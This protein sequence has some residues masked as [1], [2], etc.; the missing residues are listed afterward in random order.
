MLLGST[1]TLMLT[2]FDAAAVLEEVFYLYDREPART[3]LNLVTDI[4]S[5]C[6]LRSDRR[7]VYVA[8]RGALDA[9]LPMA[10]RGQSAEVVVRLS[11]DEP[12]GT[13]EL[14]LSQDVDRP[15]DSA[16]DHWF[17]LQWR[18]R[19]GGIASGIGLL[20][21]KRATEIHG[22]RLSI[23]PRPSPGFALTLSFPEEVPSAPI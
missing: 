13:V 8:M 22:G 18:E 17:D 10:R 5:P 9:I 23:L 19:P 15:P 4:H 2:D 1:P 20:A 21:A 3:K 16:W 7:L 14:Q 12:T 11:R 6:V